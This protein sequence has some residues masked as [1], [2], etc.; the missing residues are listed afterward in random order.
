MSEKTLRIA[1]VPGDG[2]GVETTREAVR[3]LEALVESGRLDASLTRLPWSAEHY[4]ATG[5]TVPAGA[6]ERLG[7]DFDAVLVGAFGDPRVKDNRHAREI[8]LGMRFKL[9]LF[10]N[11]RPVKCLAD[12]LSPLKDRGASDIDFVVFRE[13]T[14]GSYVGLGGLFKRD[15]PDEIALEEDVTTRKGVE[16]ISREAFEFARTFEKPKRLSRPPRVL[17]ADK[18]NVHRFGGDLWNRVFFEVAEGYPDCEASHMFVDALTMQIVRD[19]GSFDVIVTNNMFGDIVTDLGAALQ[20]GLGMAASGNIHPGR[21]SVFEPI[22]G[23]APPLAGKGVANPFGSILTVQMMLAHLGE[24]ETA[25][26][27][28]SAVS[29]CVAAGLGTRDIGGTLST[30]EAADAVLKRL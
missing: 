23:S 27:I 12:R 6:F 13:N 26:K 5:E 3:V 2:I 22:H 28:E 8:L 25:A 19:P 16:R 14:E 20:G 4:L 24:K 29:E 17:M 18:H 30:R 11:F 15:T 9:D 1:I 21:I 10:V 7:A